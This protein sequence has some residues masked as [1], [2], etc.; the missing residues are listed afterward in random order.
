M[1]RQQHGTDDEPPSGLLAAAVDLYGREL[2]V[3]L[4]LSCPGGLTRE[5]GERVSALVG[6]DDSVTRARRPVGVPVPRA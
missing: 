6:K 1:A 2:A 5:V 4:G 3:R